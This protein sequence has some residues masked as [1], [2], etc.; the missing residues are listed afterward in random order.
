MPNLVLSL[1][2][3][4]LRERV[5]WLCYWSIRCNAS[6]LCLGMLL[7]QQVHV[8]QT[9]HDQPLSQRYYQVCFACDPLIVEVFRPTMQ[10]LYLVHARPWASLAPLSNAIS[11]SSYCLEHSFILLYPFL[12]CFVLRLA[13]C[14]SSLAME[15][16]EVAAR[17]MFM[18]IVIY[19]FSLWMDLPQ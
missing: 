11:Q 3:C 10:S 8:G 1:F 5:E 6:S 16:E 18:S 7:S 2:F 19:L 9:Y 4:L 14:S 12:I 17:F 15:P 13:S